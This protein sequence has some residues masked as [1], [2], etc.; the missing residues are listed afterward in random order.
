MGA[1]K[2]DSLADSAFN[3]LRSYQTW[4]NKKKKRCQVDLATVE[5][6]GVDPK[7]PTLA[8]SFTVGTSLQHT[9]LVCSQS[10]SQVRAIQSL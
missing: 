5:T 1:K 7:L 6:N 3:H 8:P 4:I 9:P 2:K 10:F